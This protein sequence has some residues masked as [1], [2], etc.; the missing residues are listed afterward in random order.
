M[1]FLTLFVSLQIQF[2]CG[3]G[4]EGSQLTCPVL[5]VLPIS[6]GQRTVSAYKGGGGESPALPAQGGRQWT[7]ARG[8]GELMS[9][10]QEL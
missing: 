8:Y 9:C 1:A 7:K 3:G 2:P 5:P 4:G 10:I 6:P